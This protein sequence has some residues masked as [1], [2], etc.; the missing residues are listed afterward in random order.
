MAFNMCG[1]EEKWGH[2]GGFNAGMHTYGSKIIGQLGVN[3]KMH[4]ERITLN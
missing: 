3:G 4:T 2:N 1:F